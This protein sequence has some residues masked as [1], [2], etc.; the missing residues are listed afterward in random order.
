MT[1][2]SVVQG[3]EFDWFARDA[4]GAI[5]LFATAGDGSVPDCVLEAS[6][7]HDHANSLVSVSGWGSPHVW[8]SYAAAGLFAYDW[9]EPTGRYR[10]VASPA[11]A[12]PAHL[13]VALERVKLPAV[14]TLFSQ[15][16]ELD[17][18]DLQHVA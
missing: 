3:Q 15:A 17:L 11:G 6:E 9:H 14:S 4:S 2:I 16:L 12:I 1:T 7:L 5:A 8:N 18:G 10:R 13:L